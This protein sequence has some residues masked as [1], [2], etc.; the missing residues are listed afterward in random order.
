VL[1]ACDG[2]LG[3]GR[4]IATVAG[5]LDADEQALSAELVPQLRRLVVDG[6]L[7]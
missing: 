7:L 1:G 6:F 4:I 5:L 3:L 2:D